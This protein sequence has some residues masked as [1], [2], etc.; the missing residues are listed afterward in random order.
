MRNDTA[1]L[2]VSV[3]A[4]GSLAYPGSPVSAAAQSADSSE[5]EEIVVTAQRREERLQEVPI[6]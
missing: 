4:L 2:F 1:L 6:P 5:I 3:A